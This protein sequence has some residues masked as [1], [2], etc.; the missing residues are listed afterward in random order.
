MVE[1]AAPRAEEISAWLGGRIGRALPIP[2]L[3]SAGLVFAG[4]RMLVANG[5]PV[6]QLMYTRDQGLPVALCISRIA[7]PAAP[8][9]IAARGALRLASWQ[10]GDF[11]Y[12]VAGEL[13]EGAAQSIA[14][15]A[16]QQL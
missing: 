6:A 5:R 11:A 3:T 2:D 10:D 9:E 15:R 1:M 7:G 14:A 13:D 8:L 12:V 16:A 4:G